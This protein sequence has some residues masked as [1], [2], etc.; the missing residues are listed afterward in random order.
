MNWQAAGAGT[1][2]YS[3]AEDE[4]RAMAAAPWW[5][6]AAPH[7]RAEAIT[8]RMLSGGAEWWLFGAW[9][10]WYRCGLDGNWHACPPPADPA[11]RRAPLTAPP[12]AGNPPVPPALIPTGPDL[13][14]GRAA[15]AGF[16]GDA[17]ATTLVA[18]LQQS[19][20][21][22]L[23]VNP[24]QFT[25]Q[26]PAFKP[27]TPSTLAAAWGALLWCAGSPVLLDQHPLIELFVSYLTVPAGQ[28]RWMVPPDL[29]RLSAYYSGRLLAGDA[30]GAS[31]VARVMG[32]VAGGLRED[33]RFRPGADALAAITAT[34]VRMVQ[35][36][37]ATARYGPAAIAQEWQRR[38]PAEHALPVLREIAPGEYLRLAFYDLCQ[39]VAGLQERPGTPTDVRRA[40]AAVLAADLQNTPNV[41]PAVLPWLDPDSA[42]VVQEVLTQPS[43]P[44]REL[45]PREGRLPETL[46]TDDVEQLRALL[47]TS[48]A[49]ALS[50]SRLARLNPPVPGFTVPAATAAELTSPSLQI[51]KSTGELTP[52][53]IIDAARA[54]L[55]AERAAQAPPADPSA[56]EPVSGEPAAGQ[57]PATQAAA[58]PDPH[59]PATQAAFGQEA[60]PP[61]P[62]SGPFSGPRPAG[63]YGD[64]PEPP[65]HG[66]RPPPFVDLPPGTPMTAPDP[67]PPPTW[68]QQPPADAPYPGPSYAPP[69]A[70]PPPPA[71]PPTDPTAPPGYRH[72]SPTPVPGAVATGGSITE[73]YGIRFLCGLDDVGQVLVEVRRRGQ[74][75]KRLRGQEMSSASAPALLFVGA[76]STGQRRLSRMVGRTLAEVE[77][78]S[79]DVHGFDARELLERGPEGVRGMLDE[80]A[81]HTMLLEG[82]DA[83][84]LDSP[85]GP[86]FAAALYR[87][88]AE[89]VSDTTLVATCAPDRLAQLSAAHPEL[90]TDFRTV[91]L[92]D[93][94]DPAARAALLE[95]L[96]TERHLSL[97][98]AA[99]DVARRDLNR[100]RGRG[101]L[102]G[103]RVVEAYL[104]RAATRHLGQAD[105][106]Q[107]L[108]GGLVLD[109]PDFTGVAEE[110]EPALRDLKDVA[111]YRDDLRSL[112]GMTGVKET[113]ER[114]VAEAQVAAARRHAG[115]PVGDGTRHLAFAGGPGSGKS[116]VARLL[117]QMYAAIGLLDSGH[118][119]ECV[120]A[121]L[122]ASGDIAA[123]VR[124]KA[125]EALGGILVIDRAAA[126]G[127]PGTG[128][129]LS[130]LVKVMDVRRDQVV[131]IYSD[132]QPELQHLVNAVPALGRRIGEVLVFP[133]P[134]D[135][136]LVAMF[137]AGAE[138]QQYV[139]D[140]ELLVILPERLRALRQRHDFA[141][142]RSV[143]RLFDDAVAQQSLRIV[144]DGRTMSADQLTRLTA[145]DLP[146]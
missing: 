9:G 29:S 54:H 4:V 65:M 28:L 58:G 91:R 119:V 18:R 38:C 48:H 83:L 75:A 17:P 93:L 84:I 81:G 78:S 25:L 126:L 72:H 129:V 114:M 127:E 92:P 36:D 21:T 16:L 50:W 103:A 125:A 5:R 62:P 42:R 138:Q 45:W 51:P 24:A 69:V 131:V 30:V 20:I 106:T 144:R 35:N 52:W 68:P 136:E 140:Q 118:V 7:Q 111:G 11:A 19:L 56:A 55:A 34:T 86:V 94:T 96:A 99:W 22:A 33:P 23:S 141:A 46:R 47:A 26:D 115:L 8:S 40:G 133:D 71:W 105:Q 79:G 73:A 10:R 137:R 87:A 44:L 53:Q 6:T 31:Y 63:P 77:V 64:D 2:P 123:A 100:I 135:Q 122:A 98:T 97:S 113:I 124:A 142:G 128:A 145:E 117:G 102:T 130:E 76:P 43:H 88:R 57:P 104:D 1:D 67:G 85:Q 139:L 120:P 39:I 32:E 37:M 116:T 80:H 146:H 3:K 61:G 107:S 49:L 82:L 108:G 14:A 74:W 13:A 132:R 143:R 112:A 89:G 134:T 41:L 12:G 121:E 59:D 90:V 66:H 109:P 101:R 27:G 70:D 110:L 60:F 95:V 15:T